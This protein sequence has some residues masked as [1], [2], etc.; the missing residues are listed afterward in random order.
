MAFLK[1]AVHVPVT[2]IT[3]RTNSVQQTI[4]PQTQN[5]H[6]SLAH[7]ST[8]HR[9]IYPPTQPQ[10]PIHPPRIQTLPPKRPPNRAAPYHHAA[11]GARA[12]LRFII[13]STQLSSSL[14][15]I[16]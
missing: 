7:P 14:D 16:R 15:K 8:H 1:T 3:M 6:K 13:Y 12:Q 10:R 4:P 2:V 9:H 11:R 5:H